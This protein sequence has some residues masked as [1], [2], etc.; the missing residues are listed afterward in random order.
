MSLRAKVF[1]RTMSLVAALIITI[2]VLVVVFLIGTHRNLERE[3]GQVTTLL[4]AQEAAEPIVQRNR[5]ALETLIREVVKN[6]PVIAYALVQRDEVPLAHTF[7]GEIPE[8]LLQMHPEVTSGSEAAGIRELLENEEV[9]Y[10][11]AAAIAQS[12]YIE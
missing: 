8:G 3:R 10:D 1:I 6:D 11:L 12:Q 5:P 2:C 7:E 9:V 4:L